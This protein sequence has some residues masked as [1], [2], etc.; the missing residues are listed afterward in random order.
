VSE[1]DWTQNTALQR[2]MNDDKEAWKAYWEQQGQPWR[3]KP[4]IEEGRKKYLAEKP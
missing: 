3:T 2:P 1:H 4:E